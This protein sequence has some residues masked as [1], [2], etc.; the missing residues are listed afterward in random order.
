MRT[1]LFTAA[2]ALGG[3]IVTSATAAAR[4]PRVNWPVSYSPWLPG[5]SYSTVS[6]FPHLPGYGYS[7][8]Y[9]YPYSAGP[10]YSVGP[11]GPGPGYGVGGGDPVSFIQS[12]YHHYLHRNPDP[13]GMRTW[14]QRLAQFNG[15]R[16][17]VT[18][19][20]LQ[21]AKLELNSNNPAMRYGW[22]YR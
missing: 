1:H 14:L 4:H 18:Q 10:G 12:L 19:E 20:F 5:G 9:G 21:A 13:Q 15:D 2:L 3:L 22:G 11:Y 7:T 16:A 17:R 6:G 8:G